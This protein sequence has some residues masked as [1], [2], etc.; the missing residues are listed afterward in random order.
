[1]CSVRECDKHVTMCK[2][3]ETENKNQHKI[4][5]RSLEWAQ[6]FRPRQGGQTAGHTSFLMTMADES[7]SRGKDELDD[8]IDARKEIH[9]K[10]EQILQ[11]FLVT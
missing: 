9:L 7:E 11:T 5:K 4:Y 1:M 6:S 3:H 8:M 10:Q 2:R